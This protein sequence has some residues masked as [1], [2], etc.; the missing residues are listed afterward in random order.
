MTAETITSTVEGPLAIITIEREPQLNAFTFAMINAIRDQVAAATANPSVYAIAI[1]GRGR[2]FSA[3]LDMEDLGRS[4]RGE[5]ESSPGP[6]HELP[7]LFSFILDVPKPVIAAVNGVAAGGGLVLAM[8]CDLRFAADTATF[9]TAFAK[10][11]LIAE[12]ATAW[13]LPRLMGT[14]RALDVLWSAR[15]FGAD[16]A[17]RLGFADRVVPADQ[18]LDEVRQYVAE[19]SASIAPRSVA[20]MKR[21]V[22]AGLSQT[23][24]ESCDEADRLMRNSLDHPD[25][26]EGVASFVE[27]RPPRFAALDPG[28]PFPPSNTAAIRGDHA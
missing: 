8:M 24:A 14:S 20:M 9:T 12:H 4:S 28:E 23:I 19:M 13:L 3:G 25:L 16:E 6:S 17:L 18:L 26:V 1:T 27:R 5:T 15:R 21:Q 11:G 22:Y 7:A 10:R 2:A